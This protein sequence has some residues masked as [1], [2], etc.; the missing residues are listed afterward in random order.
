MLIQEI[1]DRN[2][3][4]TNPVAESSSQL[5]EFR[6]HLLNYNEK[7]LRNQPQPQNQNQNQTFHEQMRQAHFEYSCER[8]YN[9]SPN[10]FDYIRANNWERALNLRVGIA[11][12]K[13]FTQ[14]K[15]LHTQYAHY[16]TRPQHGNIIGEWV[17]EIMVY[18]GTIPR[19]FFYSTNQ[20]REITYTDCKIIQSLEDK[21]NKNQ[22]LLDSDGD[23]SK[24]GDN[25]NDDEEENNMNNE[26]KKEERIIEE[27]NENSVEKND[28][29]S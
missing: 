2:S 29:K 20:T 15:C 26:E 4:E 16:I 22:N 14:V 25:D 27:G 23:D 17:H 1:L 13:N 10:D 3:L 11:G 6:L 24:N 28:E 5:Q 8:W 12:L 18:E 7:K 19:N 21:K 9:I